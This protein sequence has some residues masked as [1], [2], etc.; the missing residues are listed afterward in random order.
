[1]AGLKREVFEEIGAEIVVE[2]ILATGI[3]TNFGNQKVFFVIYKATLVDEDKAFVLESA[4]IGKVEWYD[5]K[6]FFTLPIIYKEYH[7]TLK[8]VIF[9]EGQGS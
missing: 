5:P 3:F 6:E 4:E 9:S 2:K 8:S 1:M 7:E